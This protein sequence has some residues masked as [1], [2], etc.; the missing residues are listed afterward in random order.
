MENPLGVDHV[1]GV[2]ETGGPLEPWLAREA[3]TL[4]EKHLA[5]VGKACIF[6]F[7]S[8][9]GTLWLCER[10][11]RTI[12]VEHNGKWAGAVRD[13]LLARHVRNHDMIVEPLNGGYVASVEQADPPYDLV[14]VDGRRR[15]RCVRAAVPHI[16]PGGLLVLDNS[17]REYYQPAHDLLSVLGWFREET[18]NSL[19][20]TT[21]WRRPA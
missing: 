13:L 3:I 16:K 18:W 5:A 21:I 17:E 14:I 6:E 15:V 19:W 2:D 1:L 7:G 20:H 10:S 12:S 4:I 9:S 11:E 8:G